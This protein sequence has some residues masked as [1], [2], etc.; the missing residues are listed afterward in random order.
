MAGSNFLQLQQQQLTKLLL[1]ALLCSVGLATAKHLGDGAADGDVT[2]ASDNNH[3]QQQQ[4]QHLQHLQHLQHQQHQ[5][6][7][8][9]SATT[10]HRRRLQRDSRAKD[11]AQQQ[12]DAVKGFFESIDIR[13]SG[14]FNEK[15]AVCGGSC[16]NN[17]TEKELRLKASKKYE[18]LLHHHTNSLRGILE[19]TV[20]NFQKHVLELAVQSENRT[21]SVFSK[22]YKRMVPLTQR[23]IHQLYTEIIS[24]LK[25]TEN[26]SNGQAM[27]SQSLEDALHKFFEQLFPIAYHQVVHH[28]KNNYRDLHED[29]INCLRHNF[30]ELQPF[31]QIPKELQSNLMQSV[32]MSSIFM[33]SLIQSAEVLSETDTLYG[34]QLTDTC[35]MHLLKMHYC[36]NCNE[37]P[38]HG[39]P[40]VCYSYCMNVISGC[41]AEFSGLLDSP[42][43]N[44]VEALDNLVA[45]HIRSD[46]GI[47]NAIK[48]LDE[49]LSNA[50][51]RAMQN[52]PDLEK[53]V[54][55]T[56]GTPNLLPS[57]AEDEPETLQP[58][59]NVKWASPP[60]AAIVHF[61]STI[62]KSKEFFTNIVYN[63][64]DEDFTQNDDHLCWTGDRV[65]EYTQLLITPGSDT[66]RY[67]PEVPLENQSQ[68]S[69]L[70]ELV[71][72]LIKIRKS[73]G[74]PVVLPP[75][76]DVQSDMGHEGS[77][78]GGGQL[79]DDDDEY[80]GLNGD[81]SGDG[82]GDGP[83]STFYDPAGTTPITNN[84]IESRDSPKSAASGLTVT[85]PVT[86]TVTSLLLTLVTVYSSCS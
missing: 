46:S 37:H 8:Q 18:D 67:N 19:T 75:M 49:H 81:G 16:C 54:K 77:G 43:S 20:E 6:Q 57:L 74:A 10:H 58:Y 78:G 50:I 34:K 7:H 30:D 1:V 36:P 53:K 21:L 84:D 38:E 64:C 28:N 59:G 33:N 85:V 51:M 27:N 56:C 25:Y 11:T 61:L 71:D 79:N 32:R 48:L 65:G 60:D 9:H 24:H 70:N 69:K 2:A 42:W 23:L 82:S 35:K 29:Y 22:V 66:Q 45:A 80:G 52:G 13:T 63:Y 40:K 76:H 62:E 31:D 86:V 4:H 15:G 44:V 55:K 5:H 68:Q 47:M 3:H 72:K 83:S 39:R 26:Y 41:S 17:D 14:F 12:C 73:I